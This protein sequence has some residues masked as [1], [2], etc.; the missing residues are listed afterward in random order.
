MRI[1]FDFDGVLLHLHFDEDGEC[2]RSPNLKMLNLFNSLQRELHEVIIL[3]SRWEK[4]EKCSHIIS[5]EG[6]CHQHLLQP[7]ATQFTNGVNKG[8]FMHNQL[9]KIDMH[10][11][12]DPTELASLPKDCQG[13]LVI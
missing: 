13:I 6:F 8:L 9:L 5:V 4:N 11:D 2:I 10:F 7:H 3:T 1:S 12:D